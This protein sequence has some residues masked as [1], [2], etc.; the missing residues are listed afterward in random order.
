MGDRQLSDCRRS[1]YKFPQRVGQIAPFGK[2][3]VEVADSLAGVDF[4]VQCVRSG[5]GD[6]DVADKGGS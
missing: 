2:D 5:V 3:Q 4:V 1:Q 6:Q